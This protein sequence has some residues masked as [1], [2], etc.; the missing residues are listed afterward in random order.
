MEK[1][2]INWND[3]EDGETNRIKIEPG[4]VYHLKFSGIRQSTMGIK[5]D[6]N[7]D[8]VTKTIP[9]LL[10]AIRDGILQTKDLCVTSK[11][12]AQTIR[13]FAD[14]GSLLTTRFRIERI[15]T[16]FDT[17]YKMEKEEE[18]GI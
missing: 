3:F 5:E 2:G 18:E 10:L 17:V 9:I 15:G 16:G 6:P 8:Q 11:N 12:F 14:D 4:A 13:K 7:S 1:Y